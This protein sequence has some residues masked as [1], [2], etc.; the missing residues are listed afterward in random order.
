MVEKEKPLSRISPQQWKKRGAAHRISLATAPNHD[1]TLH[2]ESK[3]T[4]GLAKLRASNFNSFLCVY[5]CL[6]NG[7]FYPRCWTIE[8]SLT[9]L[10]SCCHCSNYRDADLTTIL[11]SNSQRL[12]W[13]CD[14][15]L[16]ISFNHYLCT[17]VAS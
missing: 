4:T 6:Y 8:C 16:S 14:I 12:K 17:G 13:L 5:V 3:R 11:F 10:I 15:C 9:C 2:L 7:D 1:K